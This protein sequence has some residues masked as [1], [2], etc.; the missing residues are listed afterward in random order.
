R[1][2]EPIMINTED[3]PTETQ[4]ETEN[5]TLRSAQ[6]A[7]TT[8][9]VVGNINK[10]FAFG[11][12]ETSLS[13]KLQGLSQPENFSLA[14][15]RFHENKDNL[16][17]RSQSDQQSVNSCAESL[18][19]T[20][21]EIKTSI[22]FT[23]DEK[24]I[25][26]INW[27]FW[28]SV[29][30]DYDSVVKNQPDE[31]SKLVSQGIPREL[32]GMV[33]Q[34][35]CNSKS[36]QLEEFYRNARN[37]DSD[38]EKLIKRDLAR[39]SFVTNSAVK[40]RID[41]LFEIIKVYSLFDSEVGYTQGMAFITVPLLMNMDANESFCMLVNLMKNYGFRD[42]YLPEMTGLHI[43]LY[44][45]DRL[46]EDLAPDLHIH[47]KRQGVRSSMY[48]T[49]W[50]LTLFG[51]KFPLE[52]VLRIYDFVIYEGIES[53]LKFAV[54]LMI[55]N[56]EHLL[57]LT[58]DDLLAFLKDKLFFYYVDNSSKRESFVT[59]STRHLTDAY[60]NKEIT[61]GSYKLEEFVNDSMAVNIL[62]ITLK[63]YEAEYEEIN[64]LERER[65]EEIEELRT[66]N[67][68]L[69]RD[70]R[71]VE[72]AYAT[73]NREHVD[74]ANEMVQGKV[75]IANLQDENQQLVAELKEMTERLE[76]LDKQS[77]RNL[78]FT[79]EISENMQ[80]EIQ[81]TMQRN[82]EVME[83]NRLLEEQ[84]NGL[85]QQYSEIKKELDEAKGSAKWLKKKAFW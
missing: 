43:K 45:F 39:T 51:Y 70:I 69:T 44:Q 77:D 67:G 81:K 48:A 36:S 26:G 27:E 78:D 20:F 13:S 28:S 68:Q 64:R 42:L 8:T 73:L 33:W 46:L 14:L 3:V 16:L 82:L 18:R 37:L 29:V 84:L 79:G 52:M 25:Q 38:Y 85:E 66:R 15:L 40:S 53:I 59:N 58:F 12:S 41:D 21:N 54:N 31:L 5:D 63:R 80:L 32:R 74:I 76:H 65:Q 61:I 11:K 1:D 10:W 75:L 23:N 57:K 6:Q 55:K 4:L 9:S 49:Q 83:E 72:A 24:L 60:S 30:N 22:E 50:F 35:I 2:E 71:K 47:L 62:P 17:S 34:L 19:K 56:Q 7:H